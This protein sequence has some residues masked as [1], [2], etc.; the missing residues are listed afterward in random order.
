[1][2]TKRAVSNLLVTVSPRGLRFPPDSVKIGFLTNFLLLFVA[3]TNQFFPLNIR[4]IIAL[5]CI[6]DASLKILLGLQFTDKVA[7]FTP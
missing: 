1:M 5:R 7:F 2:E 6:I 3:K 4:K